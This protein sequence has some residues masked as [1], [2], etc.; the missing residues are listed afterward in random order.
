MAPGEGRVELFH[1]GQWGT[2]CDDHWDLNDANVACR[3]LGLPNAIYAF[4]YARFGQGIG[5]IWMDDVN[6]RGN[7]ASLFQCSHRGLGSHNCGHGEDASVVCGFPK[8]K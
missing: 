7:E 1:N 6:C 8:R 3:S 4:Q 5:P 2:V